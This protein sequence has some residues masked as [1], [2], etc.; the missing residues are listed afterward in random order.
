VHRSGAKTI[1]PV[2]RFLVSAVRA[3]PS[4][5]AEDGLTKLPCTVRRFLFHL[6][7][8][9]TANSPLDRTGLLDA[10][11]SRSIRVF[12]GRVTNLNKRAVHAVARRMELPCAEAPR[13]GDPHDSRSVRRGRSGHSAPALTHRKGAAGAIEI[14]L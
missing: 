1:V 2:C 13:T 6:D 5:R 7:L 3:R 10:L 14:R 11:H 8:T 9:E 12:N 4:D